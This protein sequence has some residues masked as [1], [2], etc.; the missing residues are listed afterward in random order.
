MIFA[1]RVVHV[2]IIR[3]Y[4]FFA[5]VNVFI[6]SIILTLSDVLIYYKNP[7]T[8][9]KK[10]VFLKRTV[11]NLFSLINLI[12]LVLN[13]SNKSQPRYSYKLKCSNK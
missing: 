13:L 3:I 4:T 2:F 1:K 10:Y 12:N 7:K 8:E 6:F 9:E 11:F 5:E